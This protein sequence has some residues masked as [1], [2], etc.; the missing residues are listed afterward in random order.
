VLWAQKENR[1]TG[2]NDLQYQNSP[3]ISPIFRDHTVARR[4]R[5]VAQKSQA[6]SEN[7]NRDLPVLLVE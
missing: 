1:L 2:E 3:D 4:S 5:E 6:V 7:S